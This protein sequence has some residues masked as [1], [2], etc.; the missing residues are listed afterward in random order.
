MR[1]DE[2]GGPPQIRNGSNQASL[3][4]VLIIFILQAMMQILLRLS[5]CKFS[6]SAEAKAAQESCKTGVK[7]L[8]PHVTARFSM[9]SKVWLCMDLT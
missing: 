6:V 4:V 9:C 1:P 3:R 8:P 2:I 7:R 5:G